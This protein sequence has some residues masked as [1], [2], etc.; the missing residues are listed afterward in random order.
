MHTTSHDAAL[1]FIQQ[2]HAQHLSA[3]RALLVNRCAEHLQQ[4]SDIPAS[5][6]ARISAQALGE[7]ESRGY[8][9]YV[10][11]DASTSYAIVIRDPD[12]GGAYAFTAAS[13]M[14]LARNL[15]MPI[16]RH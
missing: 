10:D 14:Q 7:F 9:G 6:A 12:S 1:A 4:T 13:L 2:N 8:S 5:K 3:D 11:L 16:N 15:A